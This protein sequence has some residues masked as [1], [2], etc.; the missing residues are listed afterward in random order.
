MEAKAFVEALYAAA[1]NEN[2]GEFQIYCGYNAESGLSLFESKIEKA[3]NSETQTLSFKVKKNGKIGQYVLRAPFEEKDI[4]DIISNAVENAELISDEDENFF[5]DGSGEYRQDLKPYRPLTDKLEKLDKE[6]FLQKLEK[7]AYKQSKL[8][9]KV[10]NCR[11]RENKYQAIL[12]NSLGLNLDIDWAQANATLYLAVKDGDEVK[13]AF[14]Y[15]V[16]DKDEDFNPQ[17]LAK[18][19]VDDALSKLHAVDF[20][21]GKMPAV[22]KNRAFRALLGKLVKATFAQDIIDKK[23]KFEGKIGKKVASQLVS[24][25]EDPFMEG[26]MQTRAFDY[27]GYPTSQKEI[28]KDGVLQ[29]YLHNLKT[30]HRFKTHSTGNGKNLITNLYLKS[31]ET[32]F[33]QLLCELN[34]GILISEIKGLNVGMDLVS[35]DFSV[36]GAGFLVENGKIGQPVTQFT[37]AGNFYEL[38]MNIRKVGSDLDF[39]QTNVGSP[40]VLV[41]GLT[42]SNK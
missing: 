17:S 28:I 32:S 3:E 13:D 8:V 6:E 39:Y 25:V 10:L 9:S 33:E 1:E 41:D 36:V 5:H 4:P 37:I 40:S 38:L 11:Y 21:S 2:V 18:K 30:A 31:G 27:E 29:T 12:R 19:V 35:G 24:V 34:D 7:E 16:F 42:L 14:E 20:T 15:V 23:S 22:I 26:G